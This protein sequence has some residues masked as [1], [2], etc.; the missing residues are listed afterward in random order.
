MGMHSLPNWCG[1]HAIN[2]WREGIVSKETQS[3]DMRQG[4]VEGDNPGQSCHF[5][6]AILHDGYTHRHTLN[7]FMIFCSSPFESGTC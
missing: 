5:L 1:R 7:I 6:R 2:T 3:H 4:K